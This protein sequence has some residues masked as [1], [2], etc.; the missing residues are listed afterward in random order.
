[1]TRRAEKSRSSLAGENEQLR[2][3]LDDAEQ[4]LEAIRSGKVDALVISGLEGERIFTLQGAD[5]RYRRIVEGMTEGAAIVS[6]TGVV[7]YANGA[8]AKLLGTPLDHVL[9]SQL[10]SYVP[11]E[12]LSAFEE[13]LREAAGPAQRAEQA[14]IL[15][16][17]DRLLPVHV[18]AAANP[19]DGARADICVVIT[20]LSASLRE[21]ERRRSQLS[22]DLEKAMRE[23]EAQ[24]KLFAALFSSA[25]AAISLLR[26]PDHVVEVANAG[27][28]ELWGRPAG[29]VLGKPLREVLPEIE[30]QAFPSILDEVYRSGNAFVGTQLPVRLR[31]Q[32]ELAARHIN[33]VYSPTRDADG[34]VDGITSFTIDVSSQVEARRRADESEEQFR[35]LIDNLPDLAWHARPDGY[36]EFYNRRWYEYTGTTLE[37]MHGDG[38]LKVHRADFADHVVGSWRTA[39]R[40]GTAFEMEFPLRG[41]DGVYRW[42]LT[43]AR[44]LRDSEGRIVRWIGTNTDIDERRRATEAIDLLA[45]TSAVLSSTLDY[46]ET[47]TRIAELAVP[48]VGELCAVYLR[49]EKGAR[50]HVAAVHGDA[51]LVSAVRAMCDE[52]FFCKDVP[53]GYAEVVRSGKTEMRAHV[54]ADMYRPYVD[55]PEHLERLR[56]M[57]LQSWIGVP[58]TRQGQVIGALFLALTT[59]GRIYVPEDVPLAEEIG[60]RAS[61]A[62]ENARLYRDAK[63][64]VDAERSARDKAE[65]AT[66]LKDEFLATVSH[67][68]RTPLNAI[69]GWSRLLQSD[70]LPVARRAHA[71]ETVVRNAVAQNQL[72]EDLL[73]LG[74]IISGKMRLN[75]QPVELGEIVDA[76]IDVVQP[77]ADARGVQLVRAVE[78][79]PRAVS[80][81]AGRL[82]QV[83]WNLLS[84]AVKF[85]PRGGRVEVRMQQLPAAMEIAVRDTGSGISAPFL[86]FVFDRFRQQDGAITRKTGGLG[87]GLAIVKSIV[88]LHGGTVEAR[89]AGEG[90]GS[91]FVVQL[92]TLATRALTP[93]RAT[94][95]EDARAR[96]AND[97]VERP[98]ELAGLRVLVVDDEP[99]ARDLLRAV[100]DHCA[101]K[102]TTAAS[103]AEALHR[104]AAERFD[105][106]VSDIG[107]PEQNGYDFIREVRARS[108][109][110][111]GTTPAVA[112][113]AYARSEDRR[114]ALVEGFQTHV[115]KPIDP[116][117]LVLIV[118]SVANAPRRRGA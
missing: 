67:E 103:V 97:Q 25:P 17:G 21:A 18:S 102:V 38:W 60:K 105:V 101:A 82:Q 35:Q 68:L 73:D 91:T 83:V 85:T 41:A 43:R 58:L 31:H 80:G 39:T 51:S 59:P 8:F 66:R 45:Q 107:M 53:F 30:R 47:L 74:R 40:D 104:F 79:V 7:L 44:P 24:R 42:F 20:D 65:E 29:E 16:G 94:S 106:I 109:D 72:I 6:P 81:D 110:A 36:I 14:T 50:A 23:N 4:T 15:R 37:E 3:R 87:L 118:A 115:A 70:A 56:A 32:G 99:D 78:G 111:G 57:N 71:V 69:L 93:S 48:R 95:S 86:P 90:Q 108:A 1:M 55:R 114:R 19:G 52:R 33:A 34:V 62:I 116:Q 12:A 9:G 112:L 22:A 54:N 46:E 49:A 92:P 84:N 64:A 26:G 13:L 2:A 5:H 77:A 98:P 63:V 75:V 113:T 89:S 88:E 10:R 117:E 96:A 100:L 28:L 27:A 11:P 61:L 76:A